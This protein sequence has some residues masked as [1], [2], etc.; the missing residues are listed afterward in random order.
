VQQGRLT[1]VWHGDRKRPPQSCILNTTQ[2]HN[3]A[4]N[5]DQPRWCGTTVSDIS[6]YANF[7]CCQT[8]MSSLGHRL[9]L[10]YSFTSSFLWR[11]LIKTYKSQY[12]FKEIPQMVTNNLDVSEQKSGCNCRRRVQDALCESS[13]E[14]K[15]FIN[16]AKW[17]LKNWFQGVMK[18]YYDGEFKKS[19]DRWFKE[20]I[21]DVELCSIKV[22]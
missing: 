18:M 17:E 5:S 11:R 7:R 16:N 12:I 22:Y 1:R 20:D 3:V 9:I 21:L 13:S 4:L 14:V 6:C 10:W 2:R 19:F 8:L 15:S